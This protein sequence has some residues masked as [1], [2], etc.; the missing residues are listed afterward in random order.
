MLVVND[1]DFITQDGFQ[2]GAPYKDAGGAEVETTLLVYRV[3]LPKG[4]KPY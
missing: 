2:V 3:T 1:N 4:L